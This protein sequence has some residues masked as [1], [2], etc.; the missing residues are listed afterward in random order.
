MIFINGKSFST[1]N[2]CYTGIG[3]NNCVV[4]LYTYYRTSSGSYGSEYGGI[5]TASFTTSSVK[6]TRASSG[7]LNSELNNSGVTYNYILLG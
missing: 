3:M 6:I 5:Y 4:G 7:D 1:S 2:E